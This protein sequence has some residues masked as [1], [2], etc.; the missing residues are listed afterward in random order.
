MVKRREMDFT[1][2]PLLKKMIIYAL[3]IICINVL[4]LL[5]TAADLSVLGIFTGNDHALAAV[6]ACTPIINLCLAFFMGLSVGGNIMVSRS[7]GAK[8]MEGSR[9]YVGT[10]IYLSV[11]FGIFLMIAGVLLAKQMLLWVN[12]TDEVLPYAVK[13]LRIYFLGMPLI[14]LYNFCASILRAVGD[15]LRPL[16]FL[17]IGG[18]LNILLNIFFVVVIGVDIEG[19]AIATVASNGISAICAIVIML[20]GDGYSK[21]E[22]K[23][24]RIYKDQLLKIIEIGLPVAFSKCLFSF[25]NVLVNSELNKLGDLAMTAQSVTKE[26]DG[27]V[28]EI[29]HGIGAST[30]A[31]VSQNYGAKKPDRIKKVL[32]ISLIIQISFS[33]LLGVVLI[34]SGRALCSIFTKTEEVLNLCMVRITT[35]SIFYFILGILNV[36][37]E[38][39]RG[40]GYSFTSTLISILA[41]IVL[42]FI[43][44]LFVYPFI[45]I[46]GNLT[47]NLRMLYILFPAS[48]TISSVVGSIILFILFKKMSKKFKMENQNN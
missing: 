11:V 41:N 40:I 2:G 10:S 14:M 15:T 18:A 13:Y 45:T 20:K 16:I 6:G 39:I 44:L 8:D 21:I 9:K 22:R 37:L 25:A 47:H 29:V 42:R 3:P 1:Y 38:G 19:V 4:Q 28:L 35:L 32:G 36:I 31:I 23:H 33:L 34:I 7:V 17:I 27:F 12:C 5:F 46:E 43:Y 48:W 24:F 26:I 30:V